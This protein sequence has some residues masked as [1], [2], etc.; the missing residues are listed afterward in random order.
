MS[1][2]GVSGVLAGLRDVAGVH[3]SFVLRLSGELVGKDLPAVFSDE[4]FVEVGGRLSRFIEGMAGEG[5]E[6]STA[7]MRFDEHRLHVTR[8]P[9]GI[10]AVITSN[11]INAAALRMAVTLTA[12]RLEPELVAL[13]TNPPPPVAFTPSASLPPVSAGSPGA[14]RTYRGRVI[15]S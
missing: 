10:L 15:S 2:G 5:D 8:F 1:A 6:V 4:L 13:L 7:I 11:D 14:P 9:H 12:R 3:G